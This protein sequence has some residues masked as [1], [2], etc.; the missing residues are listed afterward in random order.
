[1][2]DPAVPSLKNKWTY[3]KV[4]NYFTDMCY[5]GVFNFAIS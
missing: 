4:I 3:S 1:M 5:I 2:K